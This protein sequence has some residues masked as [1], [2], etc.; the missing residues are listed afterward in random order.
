M[1][2]PLSGFFGWAME[3]V[4]IP[5]KS[6]GREEAKGYRWT[7]DNYLVCLVLQRRKATQPGK[8]R[9]GIDELPR[10]TSSGERWPDASSIQRSSGIVMKS[11]ENKLREREI[12]R[13]RANEIRRRGTG[14]NSV[15]FLVL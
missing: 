3:K 10:G 8:A 15:L 12:E 1:V 2:V 13:E 14:N 5:H 9:G 4:P 11:K 7:R 6:T